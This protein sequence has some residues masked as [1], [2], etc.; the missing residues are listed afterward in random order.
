MNSD[1]I[2]TNLC[3]MKIQSKEPLY[4]IL[5]LMDDRLWPNEHKNEMIPE[6]LKLFHQTDMISYFSPRVF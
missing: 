1:S 5:L 2:T 4:R 3:K 6:E